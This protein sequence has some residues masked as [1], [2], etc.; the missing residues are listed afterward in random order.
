MVSS[1]QNTFLSDHLPDIPAAGDP[2]GWR[3]PPARVA[4]PGD[5]RVAPPPRQGGGS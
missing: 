2:P 4:G 1:R 5:A 3:L